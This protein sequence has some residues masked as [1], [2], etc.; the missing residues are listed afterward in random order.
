M[1]NQTIGVG[2]IGLGIMG[3]GYTQVYSDDARTCVIAVADAVPQ[4]LQSIQQQHRIP[5]ATTDYRQLVTHPQVDLVVVTTPHCDHFPMVMAALHAGKHV[6][7]EKPLAVNADEARQMVELAETKQRSLFVGLNM[8]T[9]ASF[10]TVQA[11]IKAGRIGKPFMAR[12]AFLGNEI[13]RMNDPHNWKGSFDKAGGGV[14]LD[15]GYHVID[16]MNM[17]FGKPNHV[18]GVCSRSVVQAANKAEDNAIITMSYD[19][20]LL[21]EVT[22]SFTVLG[23]N[24]NGEAT[25]RLRL[26]VFGTAGNISAEYYSHDGK[27]WQ[28]ILSTADRSINLP[29]E[30]FEPSALPTHFI[31]CLVTGATPVVT[32]ADALSVQEIVDQLYEANS[33]VA[34]G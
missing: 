24:S 20:G 19:G 28:V 23:E 29:I 3:R 32:A 25:L 4:A 21:G 27:G 5:L 16:I 11:A 6:L 9:S 13:T 14:L 34:V 10:R 8:R 7:C 22:A 33:L 2:V 30:P 18:R 26:E 15:G 1:Q 31:D 17:L 12:I